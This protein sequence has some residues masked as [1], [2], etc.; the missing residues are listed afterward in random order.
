MFATAPM[1]GFN[2]RL[3]AGGA[4]FYYGGAETALGELVRGGNMVIRNV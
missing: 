4:H 2:R 1:Q 3:T